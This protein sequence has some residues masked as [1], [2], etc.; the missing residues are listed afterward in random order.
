M[1]Y[2]LIV[3]IL[4][5]V[6]LALVPSAHAQSPDFIFSSFQ[7]DPISCVNELPPTLQG[8][9]TAS[10]NGTCTGGAIGGIEGFAKSQVGVTPTGESAPCSTPYIPRVAFVVHRSELL[11]DFCDVYSLD[12]VT[13]SADV[14]DPLRDLVFHREISS[15]C[16]GGVTPVA[17]IGTQPC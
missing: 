14:L 5:V 9:V 12:T 10:F 17:R 11:D 13:E 16:D 2:G 8:E 4:E 3:C 6:G 7:C 1:K 15:S